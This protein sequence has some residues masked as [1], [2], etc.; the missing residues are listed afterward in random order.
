MFQ[1]LVAV[2]RL[3]LT[4]DANDAFAKRAKQYVFY[5]DIP[6]SEEEVIR[7]AKDADAILVNITTQITANII[8]HC[9][10]LR[11]IGMCCSLY[12][13]N[14]ASVDIRCA[15]SRGITVTGVR[16]Y[17]DN[18]VGEYVVSQ[19]TDLLHGFHGKR[20][21]DHPLEL[22]GIPVGIIGMG[23]TGQVVARA[24][25]FFGADV[26]YYSRSHK[27]EVEA[28]GIAYLPLEQLLRKN[29]CICTCLNKFVTLLNEPEF[30]ALGNH[31]ILF[32]TGLTPACDL[33]A[34][35]RWLAHGDNHYFCDSMMALGDASLQEI[36]NV[37]C[38]GGYSGGSYQAI[39][40]LT[41][42]AIANID[43]FLAEE[44]KA[45]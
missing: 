2:E 38:Y 10:K 39:E 40:R 9:P 15:R 36:E 26:T 18:G 20:W 45:R 35:R 23:A 24:L 8:E 44:A 31:K 7:R 25:R 43:H 34:L 14:S 28:E 17:G 3:N 6:Q 4:P 16:D 42:K 19:L 13:E 11:Y 12:D 37:S 33:D 22:T 21:G 1:Q 29:I 41:Q 5:N 27:P 30:E 32:N